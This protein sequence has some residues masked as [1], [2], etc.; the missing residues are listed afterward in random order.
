MSKVLVFLKFK[1]FRHCWKESASYNDKHGKETNYSLINKDDFKTLVS[2]IKLDRNK[3]KK[4]PILVNS[5]D[6]KCLLILMSIFAKI[7]TAKN[8]F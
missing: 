3:Q 2:N 7:S 5:H 6:K 1:E 8:Y 4:L